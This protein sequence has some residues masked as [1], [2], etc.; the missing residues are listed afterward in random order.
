MQLR[1]AFVARA[2]KKVRN[3]CGVDGKHVRAREDALCKGMHELSLAALL[4]ESEVALFKYSQWRQESRAYAL[5]SK[6]GAKV[7]GWQRG[8]C[9][10]RVDFKKPSRVF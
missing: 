9:W 10:Q 7:E 3:H 5:V 1:V 6:D 8:C 2:I 4:F